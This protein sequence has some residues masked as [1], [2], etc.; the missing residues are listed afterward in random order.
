MLSVSCF[1]GYFLRNC[2]CVMSSCISIVRIIC[3]YNMVFLEERL[4]ELN[5]RIASVSISGAAG[6]AL[7]ILVAA[8]GENVQGCILR[9]SRDNPNPL[10][11][12][13]SI[14]KPSS[15]IAT[16]Q[17]NFNGNQNEFVEILSNRTTRACRYLKILL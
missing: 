11:K 17:S 12:S 4:G 13:N 6:L 10:G 2:F 14:L 7:A 16:V 1:V 5:S 9:H 8:K 15:Q 3:L